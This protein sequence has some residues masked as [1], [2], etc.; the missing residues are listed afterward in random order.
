MI[1][2]IR[3][4]QISISQRKAVLGGYWLGWKIEDMTQD[5]E[6]AQPPG[7]RV[8]ENMLALLVMVPA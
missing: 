5:S 4:A 6:D 3:V 7:G 8:V 2:A 1:L